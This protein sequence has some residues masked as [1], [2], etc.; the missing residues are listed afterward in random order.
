MKI[1]LKMANEPIDRLPNQEINI[2]KKKKGKVFL[3]IFLGFF[4]VSFLATSGMYAL[5][6]LDTPVREKVQ[7][8]NFISTIKD[9]VDSLF[10]KEGNEKNKKRNNEEKLSKN[11][12]PLKKFEKI[13]SDTFVSVAVLD[14]SKNLNGKNFESFLKSFSGYGYADFLKK[15]E[16]FK[17]EDFCKNAKNQET[18]QN[19][20]K[21]FSKILS[22]Q[23]GFFSVLTLKREKGSPFSGYV[24]LVN[25]IS[26]NA[27]KSCLEISPSE[28][29]GYG[30]SDY[31]YENNGIT[32]LCKLYSKIFSDASK[33]YES[34]FVS[35][36]LNQNEI[37][38]SLENMFKELSIN[39]K[40]LESENL[41][42]FN[43]SIKESSKENQYEIFLTYKRKSQ[44]Y[45]TIDFENDKIAE[46]SFKDGYSYL[47]FF[48]D[49]FEK[50]ESSEN[51][52]SLDKSFQKAI[53]ETNNSNMIILSNDKNLPSY[54]KF[55]NEYM[56]FM[57]SFMNS[58]L[59]LGEENS[60]YAEISSKLAKKYALVLKNEMKFSKID[61]FSY[62]YVDFNENG[63]KFNTSSKFTSDFVKTAS[64]FLMDAPKVQTKLGEFVKSETKVFGVFTY[65]KRILN[66]CYDIMV[67][68]NPEL[69]ELLDVVYESS[70]DQDR[71]TINLF[72]GD[73]R[74]FKKL[75]TREDVE[76]KISQL[77]QKWVD[78][79]GLDLDAEFFMNLLNGNLGVYYS[80]NNEF[81]LGL[82]FQTE[83]ESVKF[84]EYFKVI[85][86]ESEEVENFICYQGTCVYSE[87]NIVF[88]SDKESLKSFQ[89][90]SKSKVNLSKDMIFGITGDINYQF[91]E[92]KSLDETQRKIE[93][94]MN[95]I[96][97]NFKSF[98]FFVYSNN[99]EISSEGKVEK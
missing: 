15:F 50:L 46:I 5:A 51:R 67:K 1:I 62:S 4:G 43:L 19:F 73:T 14:F 99:L 74:E 25:F 94:L 39:S 64:K 20:S 10:L 8:N 53:K 45:G 87:K 60:E 66:F 42:E 33:N 83:A 98:K 34:V 81:V 11:I 58:R 84:L 89:S 38:S 29:V 7:K 63:I 77:T 55:I 56:N 17:K 95:R 48:D 65:P 91:S 61:G 96:V 21:N 37:V 27:S 23:D 71:A 13:S 31:S 52:I 75:S 49:S 26:E 68:M 36:I 86:P 79:S 88:M 85:F 82:E 24:K 41:K 69:G 28:F 59:G 44:K 30:L 16:N 76:K 78:V 90:D 92:S 22:Y 3:S 18:C 57:N 35:K 93:D 2:P 97:S 9:S 32:E 54:E 12:S 47:Y 80:K 40:I 72:F 70:T 6:T